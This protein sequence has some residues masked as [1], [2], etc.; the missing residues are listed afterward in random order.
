MI[1]KEWLD[2]EYENVEIKKLLKAP[3]SA[4]Q[5]ISESDKDK[6]KEAFGIDNIKEMAQLKYYQ[7]AKELY[8]KH[9]QEKENA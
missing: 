5:G 7:R 3:I 6:M 1:N 4:L 9:L 8:Q 2:K